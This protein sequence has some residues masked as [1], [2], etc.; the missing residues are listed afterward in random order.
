[1]NRGIAQQTVR[2]LALALAA[3]AIGCSGGGSTSQA[4]AQ[5]VQVSVAPS[6]PTLFPQQSLTFQATVTGTANTAVDWSVQ[7]GAAGGT[8]GADGLY[9]A[10][11]ATGT[12]VVVA[13][14]QAAA[15][16]SGRGPRRRNARL[17]KQLAA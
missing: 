10:P 2:C 6:A 12:Y 13:K 15:G 11:T 7:Q 14:S 17:A 3:M 8:I 16:V 4:T 9:T 5:G 1:M